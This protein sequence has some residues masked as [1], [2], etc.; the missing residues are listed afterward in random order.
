MSADKPEP[1]WYCERQS[2]ERRKEKLTDKP[3]TERD[4]CEQ[5]AEDLRKGDEMYRRERMRDGR[6]E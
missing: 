3:G 5:C 1:C 4:V 2:V 6:D